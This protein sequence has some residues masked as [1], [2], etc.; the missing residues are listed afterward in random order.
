MIP[1][2]CT[3][4]CQLPST[5]QPG[6]YSDATAS[7]GPPVSVDVLSISKNKLGIDPTIGVTYLN[8]SNGIELT[9]AL[10]VTL[11]ANNYATD[12]Q[13]APEL[14]FEGTIAQ[15]LSN[16]LVFAATGYAY[17]QLANDSGQGAENLQN[18]LGAESLQAR[19]F[20]VGP[21][22]GYSTKIGDSNVSMKLKYI[23]EFGAKRRLESNVVWGNAHVLILAIAFVWNTGGL[24]WQF[25]EA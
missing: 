24:L 4:I 14:H 2:T 12:Y 16:G 3:S 21:L 18:A 10:G 22:I 5:F 11:S 19:V 15:H 17:Q 8:P 7:L 13:T 9:G 20:G 23:Y 25:G 1:A 6:Q